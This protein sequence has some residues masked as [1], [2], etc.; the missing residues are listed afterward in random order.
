MIML[1]ILAWQIWE[2]EEDGVEETEELR[3]SNERLTHQLLSNY[4][5]L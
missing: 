4:R 1:E 3:A 2:T 5:W